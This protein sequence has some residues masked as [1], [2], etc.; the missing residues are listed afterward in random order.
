VRVA[1][2]GYGAIGQYVAET[3]SFDA[4]I[5]VSHLIMRDE[6]VEEVQADV[7]KDIHVCASVED[8]R[9]PE[10]D[11]VVEVAGHAG[12]SAHGKDALE[13]G[14][15]LLVVSVGALADQALFG[16][17]LGAARGGGAKLFVLPGAIGGIDALAAAKQG[18]LERV[19]YTGRKPPAAWKD[20]PA[21]ETLDLD[22]LTEEAVHFE[23][24]A[25]DAARRY[26]KNAN[27]AATIAI[28]GLGFDKTQ[29]RLIADPGVTG[30]I[31]EI[32]AEGAF[33]RMRVEMNGKPLPDNP[34]TSSLTAFSVLRAIRNRAGLMEI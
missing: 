16:S 2:I 20:S 28:A 14:L 30:N 3:L 15:D 8:M 23:G 9:A 24:T 19:V 11:I 17:L 13:S 5:S 32:E 31:H 12:L 25:D 22:A 27:V 7:G 4:D 33:G 6:R 34:K 29:V 26:P 18:G 21:E 10:P 1:L